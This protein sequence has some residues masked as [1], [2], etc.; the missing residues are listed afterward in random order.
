M[1]TGLCLFNL[2]MSF[3]IKLIVFGAFKGQHDSRKMHKCQ[4]AHVEKDHV[5]FK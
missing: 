2:L 3:V 1:V 5:Q 4:N